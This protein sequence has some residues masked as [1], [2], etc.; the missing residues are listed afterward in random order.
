M[1]IKKLILA[2]ALLIPLKAL[3]DPA[4]IGL[5]IGYANFHDLSQKYKY[6]EGAP[7]TVTRGK[8]I[9]IN[10]SSVNFDDLKVK[11]IHAIFDKEDFLVALFFILP[12]SELSK[13]EEILCKK[14]YKNNSFPLRFSSA[15]N[16]NTTIEL[17]KVK[18]E[19]EIQIAFIGDKYRAL[20]DQKK[21]NKN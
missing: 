10:R 11:R 21:K 5:E 3:A 14:Y 20:H 18:G 1:I 13:A 15:R 2:S 6:A 19:P 16:G 12:E 17:H 8:H 7:D 4:P 9:I